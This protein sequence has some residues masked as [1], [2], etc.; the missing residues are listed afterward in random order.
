MQSGGANPVIPVMWHLVQ[1]RRCV[2]LVSLDCSDLI[3][4]TLRIHFD[5]PSLAIMASTSLI[6]DLS[7]RFPLTVPVPTPL[8]H[9]HLIQSGDLATE[10]DLL[11]NPENLRAWLS[12]ISQIKVRLEKLEPEKADPPSPEQQLLGPLS[13][14]VAREGLQQLVSIYERAIAIFPTSFKLWKSY[15]LTRQSYVLG[16]LTADAQ[17]ARQYQAKR[18]AAYKT[19]VSETLA[20]ADEA[21][22]WEGGLDGVVGYEEWR[23]LIATGERMLGWLSHLPATWLLHISVLFHPKCPAVFKRTYARRTFDRALRT[24]PP[25]LHGRI[26]GLYLKWAETIGGDAGERVWRRYLKVSTTPKDDVADN[27]SMHH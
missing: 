22:E 25:S 18:G 17:K 20:G 10:E 5:H 19:N 16:E 13:S 6:A 24:L 15:I 23:S 14:P 27:R 8:T 1:P 12:Y 4:Y 11:H 3:D 7:S 9:P 26:W 2:A 21:H